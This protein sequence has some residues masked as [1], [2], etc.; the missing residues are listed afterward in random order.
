MPAMTDVIGGQV[1]IYAGSATQL[2]PQIKGGKL[3]AL[4]ITSEDRL[5]DMPDIPTVREVLPSFRALNYQ[6]VFV[7]KGTPPAVIE[8][9]YKQSVAAISKPEFQQQAKANYASVR[10]LTPA[11]FR[12][13]MEND[14]V[15]I[16]AVMKTTP[17]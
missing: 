7:R 2:A 17:K 12:K 13:F 15:D 8:T 1:D 6:G 11:E 14:A 16:A 3:R 10:P 5:A 4:A 9:L